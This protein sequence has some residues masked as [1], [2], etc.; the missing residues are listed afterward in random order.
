[1]SFRCL[2]SSEFS[3][4]VILDR[5]PERMKR[6]KVLRG[7]THMN[8]MDL[9]RQQQTEE[10]EEEI[11]EEE[12]AHNTNSDEL[13]VTESPTGS[14]GFTSMRRAIDQ[15]SLDQLM[16]TVVR[17]FSVLVGLVWDIAF[18]SA[19][20]VIIAPGAVS[21]P[22]LCKFI[23][24]KLT[25]HPVAAKCV[26]C[27]LLVACVLPGWRKHV[28]PYSRRSW[29]DHFQDIKMEEQRNHEYS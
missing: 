4:K 20:N 29:R 14:H 19:E 17:G 12:R 11:E 24:L 26:L 28:V 23:G 1:M 21:G 10:E 5:T 13:L 22:G 3:I 9:E 2:R 7:V 6:R 25:E 8:L 18:F 15:D 27:V 16:M